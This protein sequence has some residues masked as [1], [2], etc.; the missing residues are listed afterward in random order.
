MT[1][2]TLEL[3]YYLPRKPWGKPMP[4]IIILPISAGAQYP[5]ERYFARY[6]GR[7][8]YAAVIVHR[9]SERD[10]ETGEEINELLHQSIFDNMRVIDW[11]R[12]RDELDTTRIGLL[13]T[14]M[15]AIKGSLVVAVDPRINAAVLALAGEDLPYILSHST[16]GRLRGGGIVGHRNAYLAKHHITL[17]QFSERLKETITCDPQ[18]FAPCVD[19]R[20]VLLFLGACDTIVPFKKGWE[21]RRAMGEPDTVVMLSGHYTA[22]LYLFYIRSTAFEFFRRHFD[23]NNRAVTSSPLSP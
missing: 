20:K 14:S 23:A 6:F 22:L 1:N 21:L 16:E 5:L 2:K 18:S 7:R 4:A 17:E 8:G 19:P 12:T 3:E 11:L 13:G 10:P 9:E 15:G